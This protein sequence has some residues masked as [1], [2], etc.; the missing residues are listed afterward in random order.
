MPPSWS[1][2]QTHPSETIRS[3]YQALLRMLGTRLDEDGAREIRVVEATYGFVTHYQRQ[4]NQSEAGIVEYRSHELLAVAEELRRRKQRSQAKTHQTRYE[5][6]FRALGYELD[7]VGGRSILIEE[8]PD[9]LLLTYQTLSADG[10]VARKHMAVLYQDELARMLER[11][12]AR[13]R[14]WRKPREHERLL[15]S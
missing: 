12:V 9:G 15:A 7:Q 6:V 3:S 2:V 5:D 13:R 10:G 11:A 8:L 4:G 14:L 1:P